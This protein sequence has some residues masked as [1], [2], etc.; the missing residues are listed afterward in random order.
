M[1][2]QTYARAPRG[3]SRMVSPAGINPGTGEVPGEGLQRLAR[4]WPGASRAKRDLGSNTYHHLQL[5]PSKNFS[6]T[7]VI[8]SMDLNSY[9]SRHRRRYGL[10][11]IRSAK[12]VEAGQT[13]PSPVRSAVVLRPGKLGGPRGA[14]GGLCT[15]LEPKFER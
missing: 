3:M 11:E 2:A 14:N 4:N 7:A 1:T 12:G 13:H 8:F 6:T 10:R 5:A 9:E 15:G